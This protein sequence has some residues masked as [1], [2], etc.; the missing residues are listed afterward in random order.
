MK[1]NKIAFLGKLPNN[2]GLHLITEEKFLEQEFK[3]KWF[4][5]LF[6]SPEELK[7][8][9]KGTGWEIKEIISVPESPIYNVIIKK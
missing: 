3:D 4:E 1:L 2:K 8:I 7:D 9:L 6:V 5:Y